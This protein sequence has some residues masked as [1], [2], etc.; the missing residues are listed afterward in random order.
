[1][2]GGYF[3][4]RCENVNNPDKLTINTT[5]ANI[6][7]VLFARGDLL[8]IAFPADQVGSH[9]LQITY[10]TIS[11]SF[12][13]VATP[14]VGTMHSP[15]KT[16]LGTDYL[17]LLRTTIPA[18][19]AEKGAN[20]SSTLTTDQTKIPGGNFAAVSAAR[21]FSYA[22]TLTL[23]GVAHTDTPLSFSLYRINGN[24]TALSAGTVLEVG[25]REDIGKYVIVDHGCGLY[26][27]YAGLGELRTHTGAILRAGDAVGVASTK[28]YAENSAL[29]MATLGKQ[30]LSVEQLAASGF[31]W[32]APR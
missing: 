4:V 11:K 12:E 15:D 27:W 16:T 3:I 32:K 18:L 20:A 10:G 14:T 8:Y 28:L 9:T 23:D 26:T 22:D 7:P 25:E 5:P 1:M 19:I 6:T 21:I 13:L 31:A 30:T 2:Y 17:T 24:V 29:I